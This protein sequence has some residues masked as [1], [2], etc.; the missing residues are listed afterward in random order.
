M[1][2]VNLETNERTWTGQHKIKKMVERPRFR[3]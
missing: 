3:L 1:T 2:L